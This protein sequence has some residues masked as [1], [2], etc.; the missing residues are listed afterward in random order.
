MYNKATNAMME[1]DDGSAEFAKKL[2]ARKQIQAHLES[3]S[4]HQCKGVRMIPRR[5]IVVRSATGEIRLRHSRQALTEDELGMIDL[6]LRTECSAPV[7]CREC[8]QWYP[9]H[10]VGLN[11]AVMAVIYMSAMN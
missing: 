11:I 1:G 3:R 7:K 4:L 6:H 10:E 5:S 2:A 8:I 9:I